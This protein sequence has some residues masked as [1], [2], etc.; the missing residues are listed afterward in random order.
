MIPPSNNHYKSYRVVIPKNGGR[1]FV[2]WFETEEAKAWLGAVAM[3][4]A[5]RKIRGASLEVQYIVFMPDRRR[6]DVDNF[7][8]C[9]FDALTKCGAIEDDRFVDDFHGHRR[10]DP[11]NP[12]TV[13]VVKSDQEALQL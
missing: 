2:Q 6:S 3:I 1:P 7:A 13:I 11:T 5:G 9:I 8:K 12:R 4:A 10:L